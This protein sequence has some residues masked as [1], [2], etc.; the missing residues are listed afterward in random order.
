MSNIAIRAEHLSKQYKIGVAK[1]KHH[2]LSEYLTSALASAFSRNGHSHFW[3]L[4]DIS[5]EIKQGEVVGVIGNNGAGKS[6]LLKI[7]SRIT[8]PTGGFAEIHVFW[9][10]WA[11]V[12]SC[13]PLVMW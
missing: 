13:S 10:A 5:F 3:A 12:R 8:E 1:N 11:S 2:T 4:K 9:A 7:L 6:T